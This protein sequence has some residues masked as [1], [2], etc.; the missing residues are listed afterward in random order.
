MV[1]TWEVEL[2]V[3]SLPGLATITVDAIGGEVMPRSVLCAIFEDT[4]YLLCGLGDGHLVNYRIDGEGLSDK[5]KIA[6]GTK[7]IALRTFR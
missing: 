1:G 4:P 2:Q 3:L 7:P 6:L 5:K